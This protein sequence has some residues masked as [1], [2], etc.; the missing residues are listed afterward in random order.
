MAWRMLAQRRMIEVDLDVDAEAVVRIEPHPLVAFL[1][2][3]ALEHADEALRRVLLL[4]AGRLQQE[5][6]RRG[7]A[8]HDR[9]FGCREIDERVVDTQARHRRHQVLDGA[10]LGRAVLERRAERRLGDA[11]GVGRN[12]D[13]L[14]QVEAPEHDAGI[15]RRRPQGHVDL[16]AACAGRCRWRE[17]IP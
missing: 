11:Q 1:D 5:H 6:E 15:G 10:D 17:S 8:V 16:L 7:A 12:V 14:R 9:H 2:L 4:D 13:G 3:D